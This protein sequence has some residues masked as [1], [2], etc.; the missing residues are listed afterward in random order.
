MIYDLLIAPFADDATMRHALAACIALAFGGAPI[1]VFL[2]LRRTALIGDALSHAILPGVAIAF[3]FAGFSLLWMTIGGILAGLT[4]ALL[5][6]ATA[7]LTPV[8][9]D[10]S[11]AAFFTISLAVGTLLVSAFGT[12]EELLHVLF[13][14]VRELTPQAV[15]TIAAIATA[16]MAV[17]ALV[18]RPL[19]AECFDPGFLRSTGRA[20]ALVHAI[21]LSLVVLNLVGGFQALGTL[22]AVGLMMLPAVTARFWAETAGGQIAVAVGLTLLA[23]VV[24]LLASFHAGTQPEASIVLVAGVV[25]VLSLAFGPRGSIAA[26]LIKLRHLEA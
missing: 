25:Y 18:Y 23:A 4:V 1:G 5:A 8:K 21:F 3:V 11:L 15:L 7:R 12:D 10:A 2:V 9:E 26:Q 24:G 22:M 16:T 17:L 19:I 6:G 20:G 13:G 14:K